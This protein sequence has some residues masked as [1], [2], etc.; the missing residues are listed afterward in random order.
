MDRFEVLITTTTK[1]QNFLPK[2]WK[3]ISLVRW[4]TTI[5]I[6]IVLRDFYV[7]Q[8]LTLLTLSIF[9]QVVYVSYRVENQPI[10]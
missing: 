4:A 7:F 10:E 9:A 5:L 8:I 2:Y 1:E 3:I 6:I